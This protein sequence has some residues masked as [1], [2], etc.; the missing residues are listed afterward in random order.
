MRRYEFAPLCMSLLHSPFHFV[1]LRI[2]FFLL[3]PKERRTMHQ[4]ERFGASQTHSTEP[5]K[6]L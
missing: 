2:S 3:P 5:E 4:R 6:T 1:I